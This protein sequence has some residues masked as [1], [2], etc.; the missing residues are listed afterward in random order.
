MR[1]AQPG[2]TLGN[3][4]SSSDSGGPSIL[5]VDDDPLLLGF[6]AAVLRKAGFQVVAAAD[7]RDARALLRDP[8]SFQALVADVHMPLMSGVE[9]AVLATASALPVLLMSGDSP[10]REIEQNPWLFL[11]KPFDASTFADAVRRILSPAAARPRALVADD[12]IEIRVRVCELLSLEYE[13][14]AALDGGA[15]VLQKSEELQPD[16]IVLDISMPDMSGLAVTRALQARRSQIPVVFVT[17]HTSSAYIDEAFASGAL[18]Y[19]TKPFIARELCNALREVCAGRTYLSTD[20]RG[21]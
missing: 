10:P 11:G 20:L 21:R 1:K 14:V 17:Q 5:V 18:G 19:V 9:L 12:N 7:P 3:V 13:V 2:P 15:A 4:L 16:V 8:A 6:C